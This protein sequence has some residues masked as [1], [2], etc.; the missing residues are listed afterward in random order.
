MYQC[1]L[2]IGLLYTG[3]W[4]I[5]LVSISI[6]EH[7]IFGILHI[8]QLNQLVGS[9]VYFIQYSTTIQ[10]NFDKLIFFTNIF[11]FQF[12]LNTLVRV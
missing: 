4:H 7:Q 6:G 11:T 3:L 1:F 12:D 9:A 8:R 10:K 5:Y 2:N